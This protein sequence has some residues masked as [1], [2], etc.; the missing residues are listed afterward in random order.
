MSDAGSRKRKYNRFQV[1]AFMAL[2]KKK[3]EQKVKE[4]EKIHRQDLELKAKKLEITEKTN[5][6]R[7]K[8]AKLRRL[9]TKVL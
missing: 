3:R 9:E 6:L 8:K 7:A 2:Q 4:T 5:V 1:G